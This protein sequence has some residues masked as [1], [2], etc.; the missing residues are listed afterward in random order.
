MQDY[1]GHIT[2]VSSSAEPVFRMRTRVQSIKRHRPLK[3][4]ALA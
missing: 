1:K 2:R 4:T 3:V